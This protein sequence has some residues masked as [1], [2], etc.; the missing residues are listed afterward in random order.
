MFCCISGEVPGD[1]VVSRLTGHLY[2]RSV[3]EKHIVATGTCPITS[4]SMNVD[5][6]MVVQSNKAVRP[7]PT[8]T[9]TFPGMLKALRDEWDSV[10]LETFSLKT[11][12][13]YT[14]PNPNPNPEC[15]PNTDRN[16]NH[17]PPHPHTSS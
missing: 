12:K 2:E 16:P 5:D 8:D 17:D 6:L 13:D 3:I 15:H 11:G 9:A 4:Q 7:R 10:M 14:N 1:P